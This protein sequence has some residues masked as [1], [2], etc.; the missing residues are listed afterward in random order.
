MVPTKNPSKFGILYPKLFGVLSGQKGK[1]DLF[2]AATELLILK[3]RAFSLLAFWCKLVFVQDTDSLL[4]M[5][6]ELHNL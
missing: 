3:F 2:K 1:T 4:D 6:E 5:I